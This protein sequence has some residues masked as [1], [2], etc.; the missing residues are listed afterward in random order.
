MPASEGEN[1]MIRCGRT[2]KMAMT[3]NGDL[4]LI[5]VRKWGA[6]LPLPD[7]TCDSQ[8]WDF[9]DTTSWNQAGISVE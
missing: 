1:F 5:G 8:S 7:L 6:S 4:Q 9:E 3:M 2:G